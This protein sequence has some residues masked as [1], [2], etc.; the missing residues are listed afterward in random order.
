MVRL[1]LFLCLILMSF[2]GLAVEGGICHDLI[3]QS[4]VRKVY[5]SNQLVSNSL[6]SVLQDRRGF[7]WIGTEYGLNRFD[8]YR[9]AVYTTSRQDTATIVDNEITVMFSDSYGRLWIGSNQGLARYDYRRDCF[10]RYAFPS[11]VK[12]RVTSIIEDPWQNIIVCTAGYGLYILRK[13]CNKLEMLPIGR[14]LPMDARSGRIFMDRYNH[15]WICGYAGTCVRIRWDGEKLAYLKTYHSNAGAME[16]FI[17]DGAGGFIAVCRYGFQRFHYKENEFDETDFELSALGHDT[18]ITQAI[19][20]DSGDIILGTKGKG[21]WII[22]R[23]GKSVRRIEDCNRQLG[24][25]SSYVTALMEDKDQNLW[26]CCFKKGLYL[27]DN[28]AQDIFHHI[29]LSHHELALGSGVNS[30]ARGN[31]DDVFVSVENGIFRFT[32]LGAVVPCRGVPDGANKIYCDR[33]GRFWVATSNALYAYNPEEGNKRRVAEFR[34]QGVMSMADNGENELYISNYSEGFL[35]FDVSAGSVITVGGNIKDGN[36]FCNPWIISMYCDRDGLLWLGTSDGVEC[37]DTHARRMIIPRDG[38]K[39]LKG[40]GCMSI[41]EDALGRIV[42]GTKTGLFALDKKMMK[43]YIYPGSEPLEGLTIRS[44]I[45]DQSGGLWISVSNALYY[46]DVTTGRMACYYTGN[47]AFSEFVVGTALSMESG[48]LVFGVLDGLVWFDPKEVVNKKAHVGRVSITKIL[49]NG[50]HVDS[51]VNEYSLAHDENALMV[52]LSLLNYHNTR[53]TQFEYSVDGGG[54]WVGIP[55]GSNIV[56]FARLAPGKYRLMFRAKVNGDYS[57]EVTSIKVVIHKPWYSTIWAFIVYVLLLGFALFLVV[58]NYVNTRRKEMDTMKMRFLINAT[59][60]IR[61]PLTL[62]LGP[63]SSLKSRVTDKES[64]LNIDTIERS[65]NRLLVIVNQILDVRRIDKHQMQIKCSLT[66]MSAYISGICAMYQYHARQRHITLRFRNLGSGEI[67]AWIDRVNFDK[68]I[69]NLLSNA[70]KFTPDGGA[71]SVR[72]YSKGKQ[73][74]ID[75]CDSGNGLPEGSADRLFELFFQ[76]DNARQVDKAGSGIGLH[77][78][79]MLVAMHGGKIS[80]HNRSDG[81]GAVFTVAVPLGKEHLHPGQIA[82]SG[83]EKAEIRSQSSSALAT[84]KPHL[85]LVDDDEDMLA[86]LSCELSAGYQVSTFN[87]G[88]EAFNWLIQGSCDIVV[89]DVVMPGMDGIALLKQLKSHPSTCDLPV[90]ML[91]SKADL[92]DRIAGLR[93]GADAYLAKPFNIVELQTVMDN[94]LRNRGLVRG[95]CTVSR[96][97]ILVHDIDMKSNDEMLMER[98]MKSVDTNLS[99]PGFTVERLADEVGLSRSQLHRKVKEL[100]GVTT[101]MFIRNLRLEQAARLIRQDKAD[102]SRVA[103]AVGFVSLSH[104]SNAFK[105]HFGVSPREYAQDK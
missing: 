47:E 61:S 33:Q 54:H 93:G 78:C 9:F 81:H 73:M 4:N 8:G 75:V 28:C 19:R 48:M 42:V 31:Q 101:S 91:T 12:P 50:K 1:I 67:Y 86:Y 97:S 5:A 68:V 15:I 26:I 46:L 85:L 37:F 76:G 77:L 44:V 57:Q 90:V 35:I 96:Q 49:V 34:G 21:L 95:K 23:E 102:I 64:R 92:H 22:S 59:H 103:Y 74:I 43:A 80:A 17:E 40:I 100:T 38:N 6:T 18:Y 55:P 87:N 98:I 82:E 10:Q 56:S 84:R 2:D 71:V 3:R 79:K 88:Q 16:A 45:Q 27:L 72:L 63:L 25:S 36:R 11:L 70:L 24:L 60:E 65:A 29:S 99:D 94:L 20:S 105:K 62:I 89:S 30:I 66:G 51:T 69:T 41:T 53:M 7:V 32:S 52:E 58:K 104:F 13:G 39:L 14:N 83:D